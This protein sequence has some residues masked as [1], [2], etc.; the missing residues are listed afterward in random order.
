MSYFRVAATGFCLVMSQNIQDYVQQITSGSGI[1]F[2]YLGTVR[3][4]NNR[5]NVVMPVDISHFN[6]HLENI[7]LAL[8]TVKNLCDQAKFIKTTECMNILDPLTTRYH[9][10]VKKLDSVSHLLENRMKRSAWIGGIGSIVKQIFGNL[11]END[12]LKYNEAIEAM[13]NDQ[14]KL[15]S[16]MKNNILVT[17]SIITSYNKTLHQIK[18][19]EANM[20]QAIEKLTLKLKNITVVF[21]DLETQSEINFIFNSLETALLTLSFQIEDVTDAVILTS[22]NIVHPSVITPAKLQAELSDNYK[23]LPNNLQLPI[24]LDINTINIIQRISKVL[25]SHSF[26]YC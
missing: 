24:K 9:D 22:Q 19:N 1:H 21:D 15:T 4:K 26:F 18:T 23:H 11:D 8:R 20:N 14:Q 6:K 10:I 17:S 5:L 2:D 12:G 13:Q 7:N 3:I 25:C 16:L